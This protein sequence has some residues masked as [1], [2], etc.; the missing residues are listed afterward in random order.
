MTT[1][2]NKAKF[3]AYWALEVTNAPE[4][5]SLQLFD[6]FETLLRKEIATE[7]SGLLVKYAPD[8]SKVIVANEIIKSALDII[9]G[10]EDSY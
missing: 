5:A 10:D 1:E 2:M 9:K 8:P 3:A 6:M 4:E 7:V